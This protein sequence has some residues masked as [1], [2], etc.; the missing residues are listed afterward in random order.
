VLPSAILCENVSL[1]R[2]IIDRAPEELVTIRHTNDSPHND[3]P[4]SNN[5]S[6]Q[7]NNDSPQY[8]YNNDF[9]VINKLFFFFNNLTMTII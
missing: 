9:L 4:H 5:D 3:S 7:I 2:Q 1:Y 6:P 8:D